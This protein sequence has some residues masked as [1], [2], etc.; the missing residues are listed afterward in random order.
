MGQESDEQKV[1]HV[2][3]D[4]L[5]EKAS[6]WVQYVSKTLKRVIKKNQQ[7]PRYAVGMRCAQPSCVIMLHRPYDS[8]TYENL[9]RSLLSV[10]KLNS[11]IQKALMESKGKL[12][13]DIKTISPSKPWKLCD[14]LYDVLYPCHAHPVMLAI[15]PRIARKVLQ[16]IRVGAVKS[17]VLKYVEKKWKE[18]DS[19]TRQADTDFL[20]KIHTLLCLVG[21][22]PQQLG[23]LFIV[24]EQEYTNQAKQSP[25]AFYWAFQRNL[26]FWIHG[27]NHKEVI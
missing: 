7:C 17:F 22:K 4:I 23:D 3:H 11:R 25:E 24:E 8:E 27:D 15:D 13:D 20:L 6:R 16:W 1:K 19:T 14:E 21:K 18:A 12:E 10:I 5:L 9:V 2:L 26:G